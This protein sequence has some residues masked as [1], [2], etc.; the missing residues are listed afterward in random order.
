[1]RA[2]E[3]LNESYFKSMKDGVLVA[4]SKHC[5]DR[6]AERGIPWDYVL[7]IIDQLPEYKNKLAQMIR[8]P[9]FRIRDEQTWIDLGCI[10]NESRN[11]P[12]LYINTVIRIEPGMN[13]DMPVIRINGE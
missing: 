9:K 6:A 5:K 7:R 11:N 2:R 13:Y 10:Y 4:V 1:M 3:F 8:F 12:V